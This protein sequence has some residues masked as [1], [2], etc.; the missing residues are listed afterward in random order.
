MLIKAKYTTMI[1][2]FKFFFIKITN[3]LK[4]KL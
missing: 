4:L 1:L 2:A 3:I